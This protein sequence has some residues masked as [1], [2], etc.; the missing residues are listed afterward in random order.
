MQIN[1]HNE[2][3]MTQLMLEYAVNEQPSLAEVKERLRAGAYIRT[4]NE[5]LA[6]YCGVTGSELQKKVAE[7]LCNS[8]GEHANRDSIERKV[9]GWLNKKTI[10]IDKDSALQLAFALKLTPSAAEEMLHALCGE[11]FHRRDPNDIVFLF[12]LKHQMTYLEALNLIA[13]MLPIYEAN[14]T[15]SETADLTKIQQ[16]IDQLQTE[17][18]LKHF[19]LNEAAKLGI[20]FSPKE[21]HV[22]KQNKSHIKK[23]LAQYCRVSETDI[24]QKLRT[25]LCESSGV[26]AKADE[27]RVDRKIYSWLHITKAYIDRDSA[28]QIAFA[29]NLTLTDAE[30]MLTSLCGEGFNLSDPHEI[31]L[32]FAIKNRMTYLDAQA[33]RSRMP[34]LVMTE[35]VKTQLDKI[36]TSDD[37]ANFFVTEAAQLGKMHNTAYDLFMKFMETLSDG[38]DMKVSAKKK[39][40]KPESSSTDEADEQD[41]E[42]TILKNYFYRDLIPVHKGYRKL[43]E[44]ALQ[45]SIKKNWPDKGVIS[46]M[47]NRH[48]DVTRK[49][50]ILLFLACD[51]GEMLYGNLDYDEPENIFD[52]TYASM[53]NMLI[54]CGFSPLDSRDPFDWMVLYCIATAN[55]FFDIDENINSFLSEI[56]NTSEQD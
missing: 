18:D 9:R 54:Q 47:K 10:S 33:L 3:S 14:R 16:R 50:L 45:R 26:Y 49:V 52:E 36:Q 21:H 39:K 51:G 28:I 1:P 23:V 29:L 2:A 27:E 42:S 24:S 20:R 31:V 8:L 19:L 38:G 4:V 35:T 17:E 55:E 48:I 41:I 11:G 34:A 5:I 30:D 46:R 12:A 37:L 25:L 56:F 6:K 53:N 32:R 22:P 43:V 7:C 13:Q 40:Q 44:T 15:P